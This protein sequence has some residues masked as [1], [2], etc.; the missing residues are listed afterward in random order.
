M[1]PKIII[2]GGGH[3]ASALINL[4]GGAFDVTV[5][6]KSQ[7]ALN[8]I[9]KDRKIN[10]VHADATSEYELVR[11]GL[12]SADYFVIF[13]NNEEINYEIAK[14][15]KRH[16]ITN[17]MSYVPTYEYLLQFEKLGVQ[18]IG[19]PHDIAA[20][21]Y[22]KIV[23]HTKKAIG[24]GLG[25]GEIVEVTVGE[26]API[27]KQQISQLA[28]HG[29]RI[30]GIYRDDKLIVPAENTII[31]AND[32][33]ILIGDP[34]R[35]E[36]AVSVF[37]TSSESNFPLQY[38]NSALAVSV[39]NSYSIQEAIY[40]KNNTHLDYLKILSRR[41]YKNYNEINNFHLVNSVKG[42]LEIL[43]NESFGLIIVDKPHFG[44][45]EKLGLKNSIIFRLAKRSKSPILVAG[46]RKSYKKILLYIFEN[47]EELL[48]KSVHISISASVTLNAQ[49]D[50]ILCVMPDVFIKSS[51]RDFENR[52][53]NIIEKILIMYKK[54]I[55][56]NIIYGNPVKKLRKS[57]FSYDLIIT[58]G[59]KHRNSFFSPNP[60]F[61]I[62]SFKDVSVLLIMK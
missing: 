1:K 30:G 28:L 48:R 24:I 27:V 58:Y 13:T 60:L 45:I 21:A 11:G 14:I 2:A 7:D 20:D 31:K 17:V 37:T 54:S 9:A 33:L 62:S 55:T 12:N 42:V 34:K 29:I 53:R 6:D 8:Q 10:T 41:N 26:Y 39:Y 32:K 57:L 4:L 38:G 18:I 15:A 59:Y 5:V 25:V 40:L 36:Y 19:S 50:I 49:L 35:L 52:A 22:N 51:G 44:V 61:Y 16:S 23:H 47:N 56:V 43:Q 46:G 3:K